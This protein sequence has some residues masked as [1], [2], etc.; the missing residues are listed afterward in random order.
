MGGRVGRTAAHHVVGLD[1]EL[2]DAGLH[3][4]IPTLNQKPSDP[5]ASWRR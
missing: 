5:L 2:T 3:Q 1:P 4:R